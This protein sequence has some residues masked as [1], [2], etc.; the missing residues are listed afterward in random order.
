MGNSLKTGVGPD[1]RMREL[2]NTAPKLEPKKVNQIAALPLGGRIRVDPWN[3]RIEISKNKP[4]T[5]LTARE[6]MPFELTPIFP[7]QT[8][9]GLAEDTKKDDS[10]PAENVPQQTDVPV[11]SQ[12]VGSGTAGK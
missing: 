6:K 11:T 4:V 1:L 7:H 9:L 10:K 3:N 12:A 5:L 2:T 8:R